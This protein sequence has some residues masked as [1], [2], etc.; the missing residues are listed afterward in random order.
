MDVPRLGVK[1]ELQLPAYTTATAMPDPS[2]NCDLYSSLQEHKILNPLS[3]ARDWT[4]V[5]MDT[6]WIHYHWTTMGTPNRKFFFLTFCFLGP[7]PR[8]MKVPRLGVESELQLQAYTTATTMWDPSC[9]CGLCISSRQCLI[10]DPLSE[11][12][13]RT[14]ILMDTSQIR[15]CRAIIGT[16]LFYI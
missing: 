7:Y 15:F 11:A 10:R 5:L 14:R 16:P 9:I 12:R 2:C 3:K 1:L 4:H 13:D 6:S 8:H